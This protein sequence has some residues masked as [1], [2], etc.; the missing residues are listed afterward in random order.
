LTAALEIVE[1]RADSRWLAPAHAGQPVLIPGSMGQSV[2][3]VQAE[4]G[5]ARPVARMRPLLT[6]KA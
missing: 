2:V 5:I 6:F 4:V 3:A 1:A